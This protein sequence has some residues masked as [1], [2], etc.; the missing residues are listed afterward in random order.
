MSSG[1]DMKRRRFL[2]AC[3]LTGT[4]VLGAGIATEA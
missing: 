3:G 4:A 2:S 1:R